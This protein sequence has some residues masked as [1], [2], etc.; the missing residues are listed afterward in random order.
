MIEPDHP[1]L[2]IRR[3]CELV[4]ISRASSY[5]QSASGSHEN[6]ATMRLIDEA[7]ME[8][9][10][11]MAI[12]SWRGICGVRAGAS[13]SPK[14]S[15]PHGRSSP[16]QSCSIGRIFSPDLLSNLVPRNH[17]ARSGSSV[18]ALTRIRA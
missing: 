12:V 2:S 11:G 7:F 10:L 17:G 14:P 13:A 6:L 4:S 18:P 9:C 3:Q 1:R 8:R 5:R 16:Q 15:E